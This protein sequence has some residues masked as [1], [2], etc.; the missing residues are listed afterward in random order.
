M[1]C[2]R[3]TTRCLARPVGP[4]GG[5][6]ASRGSMP[7]PNA[8]SHPVEGGSA[9]DYDYA[10]SDPCNYLDLTGRNIDRIH[11]SCPPGYGVVGVFEAFGIGTGKLKARLCGETRYRQLDTFKISTGPGKRIFTYTVRPVGAPARIEDVR[12][13]AQFGIVNIISARCVRNPSLARG[14]FIV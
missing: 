2:T 4:V 9:N 7:S 13:E 3:L 12:V 8:R 5:P 10:S 11:V 1:T 14:D 6:T